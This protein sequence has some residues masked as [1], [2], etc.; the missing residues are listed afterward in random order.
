MAGC[1]SV[2]DREK[3]EECLMFGAMAVHGERRHEEME[4]SVHARP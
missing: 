3:S 4:M 2:F 1:D